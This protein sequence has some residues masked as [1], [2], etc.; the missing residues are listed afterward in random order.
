M[1]K[2][3]QLK[4]AIYA[5]KSSEDSRRQIQSIEDQVKTMSAIC[6]RRSVEVNKIIRESKSAKT[7]KA[8]PKF[9]ELLEMVKKG[10][11]NCLACWKLDR[12]ARNMVDGGQIIQLLQE[13]KIKQIITSDRI[14]LPDDNAILMAVEFGMS[15]QFIRDLSKN[16]KR[17][18]KSKVEK[19]WWPGLPPIGYLNDVYNHTIILDKERAPIVRKIFEHMITGAYTPPQILDK[20]NDDWHFKTFPRKHSGGKKMSASGIYKLLKNPFYT[21]S[22]YHK[23]EIHQGLHEPIITWA[24]F[25]RVQKMIKSDIA[26]KSRKEEFY[27][28]GTMKCGYCGCSITAQNTTN[29]FGSHYVYYRCTHRKTGI[30]CHQ[31]Y[32]EQKELE[33]QIDETLDTVTMPEKY[34]KWALEELK[35]RSQVETTD[36]TMILKSIHRSIEDCK[37]KLDELLDVKLKHLITDEEYL[38]KKNRIMAEKSDLESRLGKNKQEGETWVKLAEDSF[39][40]IVYAKIRLE[41]GSIEDKKK[42]LLGL[43]SNPV[44]KDKKVQISLQNYLKIVDADTPAP[45]DKKQMFQ[46]QNF[47]LDKRK[48]KA[49]DLEFSRWQGC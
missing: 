4:C 17:G 16:V 13:G 31:P 26:K 43:G 22:F 9:N 36:N 46:P 27:Y 48:N 18:I 42:I 49:L 45:I 20:V 40:F 5:R 6:E 37:T 8:R 15:N 47:A 44:L 34:L 41:H 35:Q 3:T 19:G 39:N 11:I 38:N 14:C 30:T 2:E 23:G 21:G 25:E 28:G 29:R 24:E 1:T 7:P 12:L 33:R 10:E 32:L